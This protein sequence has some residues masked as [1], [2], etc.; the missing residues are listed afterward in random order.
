[1]NAQRLIACLRVCTMAAHPVPGRFLPKSCVVIAALF[2]AS[3]ACAVSVCA[4]EYDI[5]I[6]KNL[7]HDQ[8][9]KWEMEKSPVKG[10]SSQS[11]P[12]ENQNIDQINLFGTVVKDSRSYAIMRL[13]QPPA[14]L[15][16]RRRAARR[17]NKDTEDDTSQDSKRPYTVGDFIS[18]YQ[19]VEIKPESVLL[20]DPYDSK[21]YEIFMNASAIER[22]A[23]RTEIVEDTPEPPPQPS[24]TD[25]KSPGRPS[26]KASPP[27][28]AASADFIRQRFEKDLEAMRNRKDAAEEQQAD[29]DAEELQ[30][31]PPQLDEGGREEL[32]RLKSEFEKMQQ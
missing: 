10:S 25:K 2:L 7:F 15:A 22:T 18:G 4:D 31:I 3:A 20:Q 24:A 26:A 12:R 16:S 1:M 14:Q 32:E 23:E 6:E 17:E 30:S 21:R 19:V 5:I 13:T 11:G 8:R 9:Q 27:D 29:V 28:P